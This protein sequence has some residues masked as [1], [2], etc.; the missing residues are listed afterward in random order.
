VSPTPVAGA[1]AS[2]SSHLIPRGRV[3]AAAHVGLELEPY[4]SLLD[5]SV[6]DADP[7]RVVVT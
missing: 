3:V 2:S 7:I 1:T 4:V 5:A 6:V